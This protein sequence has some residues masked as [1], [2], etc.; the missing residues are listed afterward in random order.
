MARGELISVNAVPIKT[1]LACKYFHNQTN[2][3][4]SGTIETGKGIGMGMFQQRLRRESRRTGRRVEHAKIMAGERKRKAG[5]S[6]E[7]WEIGESRSVV[8]AG[9]AA[10]RFPSTRRNRTSQEW[11]RL[12][13]LL[14]PFLVS[15]AASALIC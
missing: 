4:R 13:M 11:L 9:T 8:S 5:G 3:S 15:L 2:S 10:A 6:S 12:L 7:C 14:L 1:I